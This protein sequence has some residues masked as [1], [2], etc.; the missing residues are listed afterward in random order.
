MNFDFAKRARKLSSLAVVSSIIGLTLVSLLPWVSETTTNS[1]GKTITIYYN[2]ATM[3]TSNNE[4]INGLA[5]DTRLIIDFFWLIIIFGLLSF[6]GTIIYVSDKHPRLAQVSLL[7]GC[8][9]IIFSILVVFVNWSWIQ[10]IG[11]METISASPLFGVSNIPIKYAH[12]PLAM[13]VISLI[14]SGLYT[15]LILSSSIKPFIGS[16]KQKEPVEKLRVQEPKTRQPIQKLP[17]GE[18]QDSYRRIQTRSFEFEKESPIEKPYAEEEYSKPEQKQHLEPRK[19]IPTK[20]PFPL[21]KSLDIEET[22]GNSSAAEELSSRQ[23]EPPSTSPLFE[24][25]LYSAIEKKQ[26]EI[27]KEKTDKKQQPAKKKISVRCPQC[28]YILSVEKGEGITK[29]K[30]PKCGKEGVIK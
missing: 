3:E 5:G 19:P 2:I 17:V 24:K 1:E 21:K 4:Q 16:K 22:Y 9:T 26:M 8:L 10:K 20:Q 29:I 6:V 7:L 23:D 13:G 28:K 27:N 11:T 12:L 15:W 30:C 25:A 18:K 14:G